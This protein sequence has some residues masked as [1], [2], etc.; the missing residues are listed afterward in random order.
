MKE[1][2][3]EHSFF[4]LFHAIFLP[5]AAL[6]PFLSRWMREILPMSACLMKV[7]LR[8]YCPFCGG[9]RAMGAIL[10]LQLA[11]A[12]QYNPLVVIFLGCF[13]VIPKDGKI[14]HRVNSPDDHQE[15]S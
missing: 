5:L 13:S 4:L 9:T 11:E 14:S 15:I 1:R 2:R 7:F 8:L 10:R 6:F 3:R 12:W